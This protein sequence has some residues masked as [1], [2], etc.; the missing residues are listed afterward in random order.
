M[1]GFFRTV[2]EFVQHQARIGVKMKC[3]SIREHNGDRA[4]NAGLDDVAFVNKI[5]SYR[6]SDNNGPARDGDQTHHNLKF[7]NGRRA[8]QLLSRSAAEGRTIVCSSGAAGHAK[9]PVSGVASLVLIVWARDIG[10][11]RSSTDWLLCRGSRP[12]IHNMLAIFS[13]LV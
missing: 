13:R 4:V 7:A 11:N 1:R 6:L 8:H 12:E 10:I 2:N 5:T 3:R 9:S